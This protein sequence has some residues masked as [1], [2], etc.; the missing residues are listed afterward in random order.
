MWVL[1]KTLQPNS[2]GKHNGKKQNKTKKQG[3]LTRYRVNALISTDNY[4]ITS[5]RGFLCCYSMLLF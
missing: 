5:E 3:K 2:L 1:G 4:F